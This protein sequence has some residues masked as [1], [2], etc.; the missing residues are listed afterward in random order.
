MTTPETQVRRFYD[1][2]WNRL[3]LAVVP[4]VLAPEVTFRGS[5]GAVRTGHAEFVEYVRSVTDA[6]GDYRCDIETLVGQGDQVAA[7]MV[8]GGVHRA[9]FQGFPATGRRVSWA[10]AAFFTF[11]AGLVSDLWVLGDV[12]GLHVQLRTSQDD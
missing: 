5:L 6:L 11:A 1:E 8:F 10:G 4:Q 3:D 2:I 9:M 12:Q 7:R